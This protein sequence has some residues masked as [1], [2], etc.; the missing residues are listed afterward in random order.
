VDA[1]VRHVDADGAVGVQK[2]PRGQR[3]TPAGGV[4][5]VELGDGPAR[6]H[7]GGGK[8]Q[9]P[10][11]RVAQEAAGRRVVEGD[12]DHEGLAVPG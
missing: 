9:E 8:P 5:L 12:F 1:G 2:T 6:V 4:D 3:P 10:H 7:V 11:D